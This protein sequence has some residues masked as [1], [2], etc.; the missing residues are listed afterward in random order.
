M[1]SRFGSKVSSSH[2]KLHAFSSHFDRTPEEKA[3]NSAQPPA[4]S[5]T[6]VTPFFLAV[7][8][9]FHFPSH[10]ISAVSGTPDGHVKV[11][12]DA[13]QDCSAPPLSLI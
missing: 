2:V 4:D 3:S 9:M 13:V 7:L 11:H 1:L 8:G 10:S 6:Q 5:S 12:F